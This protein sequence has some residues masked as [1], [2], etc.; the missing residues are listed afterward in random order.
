[1][2]REFREIRA[3]CESSAKRDWRVPRYSRVPGDLRTPRD[4]KV[5]RGSSRVPRDSRTS[6]Q[7]DM[8]MRCHTRDKMVHL[9]TSLDG[10]TIV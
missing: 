8:M 10:P 9:V 4:P 3:F 1:M 2:F 6:D 7:F 5:S